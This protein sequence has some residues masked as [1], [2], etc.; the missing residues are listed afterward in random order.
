[1]KNFDLI[2]KIP[3]NLNF[4]DEDISEEDFIKSLIKIY[5]EDPRELIDS[6]SYDII[7]KKKKFEILIKTHKNK[8]A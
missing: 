7:D 1:M 3:I 4:E 8:N 2:I 5:Q 6:I